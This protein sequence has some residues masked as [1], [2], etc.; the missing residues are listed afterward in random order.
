MSKI[1]KVLEIGIQVVVGVGREKLFKGLN[2]LA[3][4]RG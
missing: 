2:P 4:S 3:G 1:A